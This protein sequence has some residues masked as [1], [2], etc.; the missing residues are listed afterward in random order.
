MEN[1]YTLTCNN[2]ITDAVIPADS[3]LKNQQSSN[4]LPLCASMFLCQNL[5]KNRYIKNISDMFSNLKLAC[6]EVHNVIKS[7]LLRILSKFVVSK[8]QYKHYMP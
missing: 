3:Q 4:Q 8:N 5:N 6:A 7:F 1:K 2:I